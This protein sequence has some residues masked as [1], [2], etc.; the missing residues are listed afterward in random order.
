MGEVMGTRDSGMVDGVWYGHVLD[1][2]LEQ[3]GLGMQKF[4]VGHNDGDNPY[5]TAHNFI[6]KHGLDQVPPR[7]SLM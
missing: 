7:H 3:P 1:I 6:A 5:T 4:K 2:E